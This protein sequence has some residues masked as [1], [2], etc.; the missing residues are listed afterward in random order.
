MRSTGRSGASPM[1]DTV[2]RASAARKDSRCASSHWPTAG[3]DSWV[4]AAESAGSEGVKLCNS[5]QEAADHFHLLMNS[6]RAIGG[7][8]AAV[9][10]Q[11][12]LRG[13]EYVCDHV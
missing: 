12:F 11:E 8:G 10:A 1:F 4:K 9:I 13:S 6:Q 3:W 2:W 7:E 5:K